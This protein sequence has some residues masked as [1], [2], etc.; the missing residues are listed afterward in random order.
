MATFTCW[1]ILPMWNGG[2]PSAIIP[3]YGVG[4]VYGNSA[5]T[6]PV[7]SHARQTAP[8]L[9]SHL[10]SILLGGGNSFIPSRPM[11]GG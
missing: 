3:S 9:T 10:D 8:S 6:G 1:F 7:M 4:V 11:I 5:S 2:G